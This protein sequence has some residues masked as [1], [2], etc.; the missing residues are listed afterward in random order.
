MEYAHHQG[1][2]FK[3]KVW[4]IL[5]L[6]PPFGWSTS[7]RVTCVIDYCIVW[8]KGIIPLVSLSWLIMIG[9]CYL[10]HGDDLDCGM[11]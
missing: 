1:W 10:M 4:F 6:L 11:I 8:L 3:M 5:S 9:E 7:I 2:E